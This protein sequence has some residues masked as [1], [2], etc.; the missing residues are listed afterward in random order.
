MNHP[1]SHRRL[2]VVKVLL[3]SVGLLI[4]SY[5]A[6]AGVRSVIAYRDVIEAKDLLIS[7]EG[8]LNRGGLDVTAD[9]LDDVEGRLERTRGKVES[10]SAFLNHDP[11]LWVAR[12]LPWIG[13][14]INSARDLAQIGLESADLGKDG[15]Q[16]LR[17]LL[18]VREEGPGPLGEKTIRFLSDVEPEVGRIE[19]RLGE[20]KARQEDLQSRTLIAPL[21]SAVDEIDG[22]IAR[23]EGMAQMYRQAQVLAPGLLGHQGSMTFLVLGQDNT[24]I[25]ATGGLILFYGV[26]TLDQGKVS[27]MFFEDTEEQIAR[28]QERTGGEYIEPPGPLKHYLLRE[29]TWNLGTANWSP[30]FPT[31]AQQADFFYLKGEGE[32][33]DGVIAI[34]FTALEKLLDVL[35]PID[36]AE[37]DSVVDSENVTAL[38]LDRTRRPQQP[39]EPRKAFAAAVAEAIMEK[40]LAADSDLWASLLEAITD[41]GKGRHLLVFT[42]DDELQRVVEEIGW[43]GEIRSHEG[44][45]LMIVDASVRSTKLNLVLEEDIRVDVN[46]TA[47]GD[48][49]NVVTLH[50]EDRRE[51]RTPQGYPELAKRLTR[52]YG[53]YVRLLAPE[54]AQLKDIHVD[55]EFVGP[56]EVIREF[57]RISF[58]RFFRIPKNGSTSVSFRY[59]L[60]GVV[61]RDGEAY[62]YVLTLQKQP[63]QGDLPV[64]VRI[65]LPAG[66]TDVTVKLDDVEVEG[67][68]AGAPAA[69][70]LELEL[71][72]DTDRVVSVRYRLP[73]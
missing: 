55:G 35:G 11:A 34:D 68:N 48:A 3:V 62:E 72:L 47:G 38:V 69:N 10:A 17:K 24:E 4:V 41:I 21:S 5:L 46:L 58:G 14:Q 27:D 73:G 6:L 19:E 15:V 57:D 44:D 71:E 66:A 33:V 18:A 16:I 64:S 22:A 42:K 52:T 37:Y 30:D 8:T 31:A 29:Y 20:I 56:E 43:G 67:S 54:G 40:T 9:E 2:S 23:I 59:Q 25:A 28:W 1:P 50:Y 53:G 26:L 39:G 63:G 61:T 7:A 49:E 36:L 51:E 45:Y 13:G 12:R 32:P 60:P 70:A 65:S